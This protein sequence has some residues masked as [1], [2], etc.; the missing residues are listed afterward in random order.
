MTSVTARPASTTPDAACALYLRR[1]SAKGSEAAGGSNRS[2]SEQEAECRRFAADRGLAVVEVYREREG[3]GASAR[4]RKARPEWTRALEDLDR[5]DRF[6]TVV[7]WALDRADRRGADTLAAL[8]T[9]HAATG[10][11]VLGLDGTDTSDE[12]SRLSTILRGEI[13]REE[14][15]K[16]AARVARTKRARRE[17]GRWLGGPTPY[18]LHVVN[19]VLDHDP[20]TYPTARERIAEPLLAGA[21]L[22]SVVKALNGAGVP[23]PR[24]ARWRVPSVAALVRSPGWAGLQSTRRR[25]P[26]GAWA[27]VADVYHSEVTGE[28]VSVGRGV[29]T[30]SERARILDAIDARTSDAAG[31]R[32]DGVL[33]RTGRRPATSLLGDLVACPR[34]GSRV[35]VTGNAKGHR[36]YRCG[37]AAQGAGRCD[38]FTAPLEALD[39]FVSRAFRQRLAALDP[40]DPLLDAVAEA[41]TMRLDPGAQAER[42]EAA[43]VLAVAR[44]AL[45]RLQRG[46]LS[47]IFSEAEA[48]TEAPRLRRRIAAAEEALA[49]VSPTV[50]D[51]S[52]LLDTVQTEEAWSGLPVA[53]RRALLALALDRVEVSPAPGRGVRFDPF[54]R[55]VLGW[56]EPGAEAT[57]DAPRLVAIA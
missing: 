11:K 25:L 43:D 53:E 13:A 5:G 7:V 47:G 6:E 37:N 52:P 29:V 22:Y 49:A 24:G 31:T 48:A 16:I 2:L 56:R 8:L 40:G 18:G 55:V 42:A 10:R 46:V 38:G 1:S 15:E 21:S 30:P 34:C 23:A 39:D 45:S 14:A 57:T 33:R 51:L 41:W 35:S 3:T 54:A 20:E 36:S 12:H 44:E 28:T 26:S 27:A 9:R 32:A 17:E 50:T 4:S 19:G